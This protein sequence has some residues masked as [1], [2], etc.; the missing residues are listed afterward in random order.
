MH[1]YIDQKDVEGLLMTLQYMRTM[2]KSKTMPANYTE[3]KFT[4]TAGFQVMLY[5]I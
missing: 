5:T 4:T 1:A 3:I 2:L